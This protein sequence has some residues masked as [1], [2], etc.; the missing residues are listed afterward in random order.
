LPLSEVAYTALRTF[1]GP[2][3]R[4]AQAR[5]LLLLWRFHGELDG[6]DIFAVLDRFEA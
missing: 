4:K 6:A 3:L 5:V 2:D 1:G